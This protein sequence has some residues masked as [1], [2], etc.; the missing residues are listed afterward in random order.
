MIFK[1]FFLWNDTYGR[2]I[3]LNFAFIKWSMVEAFWYVRVLMKVSLGKDIW[4]ILMLEQKKWKDGPTYWQIFVI[5]MQKPVRVIVRS[6][7]GEES[8]HLSNFG[9]Q[10]MSACQIVGVGAT[11]RLC[12]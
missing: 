3:S 10:R 11:A 12:T 9:G 6:Y 7:V 4:P 8:D 2:F 5:M 1:S